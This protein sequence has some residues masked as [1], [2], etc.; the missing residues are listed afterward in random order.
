MGPDSEHEEGSTT[1]V[2]HAFVIESCHGGRSPGPVRN[3][4]AC[5]YLIFGDR[6]DPD[7][8]WSRHERVRAE[9]H[10]TQSVGNSRSCAEE[11][12]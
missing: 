8:D 7:P 1:Q 9:A 11:G 5:P 2:R 10:R 12:G 3:A 4:G 6:S